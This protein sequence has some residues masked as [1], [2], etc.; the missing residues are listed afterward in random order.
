MS[1]PRRVRHFRGHHECD[2]LACGIFY[3]PACPVWGGDGALPW[4]PVTVS[5]FC[6]T[7]QSPTYRKRLVKVLTELLAPEI[8]RIVAELLKGRK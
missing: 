4:S 2:P 7:L 3:D 8:G 1:Y 5:E 6:A